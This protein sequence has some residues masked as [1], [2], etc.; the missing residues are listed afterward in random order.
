VLPS[1]IIYG[2]RSGWGLF[3]MDCVKTV[4]VW[5]AL[6]YYPLRSVVCLYFTLIFAIFYSSNNPKVFFTFSRMGVKP[7][8]DTFPTDNFCSSLVRV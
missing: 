6:D 5:N 2:S 8:W 4:P 7:T 1:D 3:I